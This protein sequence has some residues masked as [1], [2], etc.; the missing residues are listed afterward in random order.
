M[1]KWKLDEKVMNNQNSPSILIKKVLIKK[2]L[3]KKTGE[4]YLLIWDY[5]RLLIKN[6]V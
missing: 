4:Y 5:L 6:K 1:M 3:I 2:V